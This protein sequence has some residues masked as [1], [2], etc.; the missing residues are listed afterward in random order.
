MIQSRGNA[1]KPE[2]YLF[3]QI[4]ALR[5]S[6]SDNDYIVSKGDAM[7]MKDLKY[8]RQI[9]YNTLLV[10]IITEAERQREAQNKAKKGK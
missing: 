8:W 4:Q 3:R 7:L 10:Q 5:K 1:A 6:K 9:E 2:R